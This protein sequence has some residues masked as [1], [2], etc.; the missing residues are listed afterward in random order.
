MLIFDGRKREIMFD[1]TYVRE[2]VAAARKRK[3]MT[4]DEFI[5]FCVRDVNA[6]YVK[7]VKE[8]G[9]RLFVPAWDYP[10]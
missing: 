2:I 3:G 4:I 9:K 6:G 8:A 5:A 1:K 10:L 7:E